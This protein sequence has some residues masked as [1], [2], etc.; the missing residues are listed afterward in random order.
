MLAKDV[1]DPSLVE[2]YHHAH[3]YKPA[4]RPRGPHGQGRTP[5]GNSSVK[6]RFL[7]DEPVW[8]MILDLM[9]IVELVV[10]PVNT[11]ESFSYLQCKISEHREAYLDLYIENQLFPKHHFLEHYPEIISLAVDN[12]I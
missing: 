11:D 5:E 8:Q 4:P 3:P 6:L 7:E 9:T 10:S 1:L 12:G 2:D